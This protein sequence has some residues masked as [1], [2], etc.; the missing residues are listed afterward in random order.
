MGVAD[1]DGGKEQCSGITERKTATGLSLGGAY[2]YQATPVIG[3]RA[4]AD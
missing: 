4:G 3:N 1:Y 2:A